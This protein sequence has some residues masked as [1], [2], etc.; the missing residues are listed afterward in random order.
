M[1]ISAA[2]AKKVQVLDLKTVPQKLVRSEI[3]RHIWPKKSAN[4]LR[5]IRLR[6]RAP[7]YK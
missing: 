2:S 3:I 4:I 1:L 5:G 7:L 6:L